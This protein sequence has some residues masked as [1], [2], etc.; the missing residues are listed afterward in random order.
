MGTPW[1]SNMAMF[2]VPDLSNPHF[3]IHQ[4]LF[5]QHT[6]VAWANSTPCLHLWGQSWSHRPTNKPHREA[7]NSTVKLLLSDITTDWNIKCPFT[8]TAHPMNG[9][10]CP[11][12]TA[13]ATTP[14]PYHLSEVAATHLKIRHSMCPI[15][16]WV[17]ATRIKDRALEL[18]S[19]W[20][21]RFNQFFSVLTTDKV[22]PAKSI[23]I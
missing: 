15:S 3:P 4:T 23:E 7:K 12:T 21:T 10:C 13:G 18:Q 8:V 19:K 22:S 9:P 20:H 14:V 11:A 5:T 1:Y 6:S 17:A 16:K 2:S